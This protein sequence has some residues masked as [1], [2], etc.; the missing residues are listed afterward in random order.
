M[1]KHLLRQ[2]TTLFPTTTG[3]APWVGLQTPSLS[4]WILAFINGFV[5]GASNF[6]GILAAII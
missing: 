6:L 5:K 4:I 3:N 2:Q 1:A